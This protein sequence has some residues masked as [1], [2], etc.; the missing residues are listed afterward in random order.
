MNTDKKITLICE[1]G[2][3]CQKHFIISVG[4]GLRLH[5]IPIDPSIWLWAA[6]CST[7]VPPTYQLI[8]ENEEYRV[9][10]E[11]NNEL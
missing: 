2:E 4:D 10:R 6:H 8:E 1:C 11:V 3:D 9:Y 7:P 5:P